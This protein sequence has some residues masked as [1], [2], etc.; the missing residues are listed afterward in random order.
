MTVI[1]KAVRTTRTTP[2]G[3]NTIHFQIMYTD[4]ERR[5]IQD[6]IDLILIVKKDFLNLVN[7]ADITVEVVGDHRQPNWIGIGFDL[8]S[9]VK[10][11]V[12]YLK[13]KKNG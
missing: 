5:A 7:I 6:I 8:Y 2:S 9:D 12:G 4:P 11:P 10:I 3:R 1:K 13:I